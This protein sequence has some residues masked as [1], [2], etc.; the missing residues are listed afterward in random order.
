MNHLLIVTFLFGNIQPKHIIWINL[1]NILH[2]ENSVL[3]ER[4]KSIVLS[5][6][7]PKLKAVIEVIQVYRTIEYVVISYYYGLH[8]LYKYSMKQATL[9]SIMDTKKIAML[10][11]TQIHTCL[12]RI[13]C[14]L[15]RFLRKSQTDPRPTTDQRRISNHTITMPIIQWIQEQSRGQ[16]SFAKSHSKRKLIIFFRA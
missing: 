6:I 7:L 9:H 2:G 14:F 10:F 8:A 13:A 5:L 3:Q 11:H 12:Q 16:Y 1:V 15:L 4:G